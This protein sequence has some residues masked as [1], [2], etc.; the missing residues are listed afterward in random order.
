LKLIYARNDGKKAANTPAE[1]LDH[2]G[3]FLVVLF[4]NVGDTTLAPSRA[5]ASAVARP[6]PFTAPAERDLSC[7]APVLISRHVQ[8]FFIAGFV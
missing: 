5:N 7:A 8:F 6:M 1:H 3:C 4:R 2:A